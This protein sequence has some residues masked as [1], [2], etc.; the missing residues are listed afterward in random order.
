MKPSSARSY[1][2]DPSKAAE[3][4]RCD[5]EKLRRNALLNAIYANVYSKL[6]AEVPASAFPRLLELGSGGGFFKNHAPHAITSEFVPIPGIDRVV[7]AARL[8]DSFE[9]GSLDAISAFNVFHHLPAPADLLRGATTVLRRGGRVVLVE[10]WFTPVGQWFYRLLHHEPYLLDP[11]EWRIV[12]NGRLAGANSR[13]P[14][15]VFR[16]SDIRF[17][18]E[19]PHLLILKREPIHKWLYL[20]SGGLRLNTRVPEF[21]AKKLVELD[22]RVRFGNG[23]LGIFALIVIERA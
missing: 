5:A 11:A 3:E 21:L 12:G 23:H 7:D 1:G 19:F 2:V 14:T 17:R 4:I 13:L 18:E 15:S 8:P 6:L 16:D 22:D 10:P 9:E 20:F